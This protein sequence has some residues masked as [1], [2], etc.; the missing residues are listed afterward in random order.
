[1]R[2]DVPRTTYISSG[3]SGAGSRRLPYRNSRTNQRSW[4]H[5]PHDANVNHPYGITQPARQAA[6]ARGLL[7]ELA[8]ALLVVGGELGQG[9]GGRP[10]GAVV[11][12]RDVVETESRVA[13]LELRR[14]LEEA[15]DLA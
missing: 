4:W 1:M 3:R 11:E 7:D 8:D 6:S 5:S 9:E 12:G 14:G 15:D 2:A 10:H 13:R